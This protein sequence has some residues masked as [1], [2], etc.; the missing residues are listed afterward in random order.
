MVDWRNATGKLDR[1]KLIQD[2]RPPVPLWESGKA[3]IDLRKAEN[4]EDVLQVRSI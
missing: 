1:I 2:S 4:D 3:L